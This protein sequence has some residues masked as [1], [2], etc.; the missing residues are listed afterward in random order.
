MHLS[1]ISLLVSFFDKLHNTLKEIERGEM[2]SRKTNQWRR[3]A[4][5]VRLR[6]KGIFPIFVFRICYFRLWFLFDLAF[7]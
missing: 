6:R 7:I 2:K 4:E 1:G 5:V 3:A